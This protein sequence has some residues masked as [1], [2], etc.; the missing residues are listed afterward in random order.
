MKKTL[1]IPTLITAGMALGACKGSAQ[2]EPFDPCT[3]QPTR[4]STPQD[5][6]YPDVWVEGDGESMDNDPCD[7]DDFVLDSQ[8]R[9]TP[10]RKP[11]FVQPTKPGVTT[12]PAPKVTTKPAPKTTRR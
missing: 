2:Y 5:E 7:G 4:M 12:K 6:G 10:V 9:L 3:V 8:G 11:Q 1:L